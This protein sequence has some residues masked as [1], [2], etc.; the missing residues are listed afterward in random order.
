MYIFRMHCDRKSFHIGIGARGAGR[1]AAH[2]PPQKKK[3]LPVF[4]GIYFHISGSLDAE[5]LAMEEFG[6]Q[7]TAPPPS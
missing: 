6:K 1:A 2:P 7:M 4:R 3:K 5:T